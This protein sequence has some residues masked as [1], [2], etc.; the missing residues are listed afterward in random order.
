MIKITAFFILFILIVLAPSVG[1]AAEK[2]SQK[3]SVSDRLA[4]EMICT[5]VMVG[6]PGNVREPPEKGGRFKSRTGTHWMVFSVDGE[7]GLVTETFGGTYTMKGDE[8]VET[9]NYAD[10]RWQHDNGKSFTF[11]VKIEGDLM[12]QIGVGNP[13]NE[14]WRRAK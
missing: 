7:T 14:V 8:Y 1:S 13:Y 6:S 9:Q 12:T 4:T 11:K 5:F 3:T 10:E 2:P